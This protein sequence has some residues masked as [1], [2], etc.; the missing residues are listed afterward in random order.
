MTRPYDE[1]KAKSLLTRRGYTVIEPKVT[2]EQRAKSMPQQVVNI[3]GSRIKV[4]EILG[5]SRTAVHKWNVV[6]DIP[7]ARKIALM[8]W[9][10]ENDP[11]AYKALS[12]LFNQ[13][14]GSGFKHG[15]G[16]R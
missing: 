5:I 2:P 11:E 4:A 8:D 14:S 3:F 7:L 1:R 10:R 13:T 16:K 12:S 15:G 9:A 6:G